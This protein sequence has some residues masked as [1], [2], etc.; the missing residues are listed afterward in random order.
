M[1]STC[2]FNL[3]YIICIS[4]VLY[5]RMIFTSIT[6]TFSRNIFFE[7]LCIIYH[8]VFFFFFF[9]SIFH[10]TQ[11]GQIQPSLCRGEGSG[12][13][14]EPHDIS[15]WWLSTLSLRLLHVNL[16][17]STCL[18][19]CHHPEVTS[20]HDAGVIIRQIRPWHSSPFPG[21]IKALTWWHCILYSYRK[22]RENCCPPEH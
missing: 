12:T 17:P 15:T 9:F 22:T 2:Y 3:I 20:S 10:K 7:I 11:E 5:F 6:M 4:S 21:D 1:R 16:H 18:T 14:A 13:A 19:A 8:K